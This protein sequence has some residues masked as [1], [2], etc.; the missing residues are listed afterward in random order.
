MKN[1]GCEIGNYN[2]L[3]YRICYGLT[4]DGKMDYSIPHYEFHKYCQCETCNRRFKYN[5]GLTNHLTVTTDEKERFPEVE[6][7]M[8]NYTCG[9]NRYIGRKF[10]SFIN[11]EVEEKIL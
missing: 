10:I 7:I 8:N 4:E 9:K 5:E 1:K 3:T 6:G 11:G 2:K